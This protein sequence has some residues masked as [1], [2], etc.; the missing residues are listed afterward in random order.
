MEQFFIAEMVPRQWK[1]WEPLVY[2]SQLKRRASKL[3][4]IDTAEVSGNNGKYTPAGFHHDTST[5]YTSSAINNME[6]P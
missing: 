1:V 3:S 5:P 2:T 4:A 6:K